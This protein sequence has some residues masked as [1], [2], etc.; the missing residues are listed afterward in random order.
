M[1]IGGYIG[2]ENPEDQSLLVSAAV[3]KLGQGTLFSMSLW[4]DNENMDFVESVIHLVHGKSAELVRYTIHVHLLICRKGMYCKHYFLA[5]IA[6]SK[7]GPGQAQGCSVGFIYSY[8]IKS[9]YCFIHGKYD[10]VYIYVF[11]CLTA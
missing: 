1:C 2:G 6:I 3:L 10:S 4:A 11:F 9:R 8:I 7:G 5:A